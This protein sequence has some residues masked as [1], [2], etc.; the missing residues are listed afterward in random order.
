[1]LK[2]GPISTKFGKSFLRNLVE[3]GRIKNEYRQ[4]L[5]NLFYEIWSK[6]VMLKIGPISTNPFTKFGRNR[7]WQYF[8]RNRSYQKY[9]QYRQ[10]LANLFYEIWSKSVMLK[11]WPISTKFGKFFYEIWSKSVTLNLTNI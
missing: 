8:L 10:N 9:D 5:A 2:V 7:S 3:I 6:S 1:M 4:N 11:I